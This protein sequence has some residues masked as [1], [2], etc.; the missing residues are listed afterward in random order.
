MT[1]SNNSRISSE[2]TANIISSY[3]SNN[4]LTPELLPGFVENVHASLATAIA[5]EPT[6]DHPKRRPAV[7]IK[8]SVS[9]EFLICL[10]DGRKLKM[11]RRHL[12]Q[13]Y[14]MTPEQY[15]SR[16]ELPADYPM[17]APGYSAKR[18]ELAKKMG[19]GTVSKRQS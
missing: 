5:K 10:E 6:F 3:V 8:N 16:W 13:A 4:N 19:L 2:L 12:K 17:V 14:G 7:P 9:D 18:S 11:L 15:R 1:K